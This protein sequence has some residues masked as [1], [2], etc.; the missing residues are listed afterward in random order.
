MDKEKICTKCGRSSKKVKFE[1][2]R[3]VCAECRQKQ[4]LDRV[5]ALREVHYN[6]LENH[7]C[8]HCGEKNPLVLQLH[9]KGGNKLLGISEMIN[10]G[11]SWKNIKKEIDKCEV[12]CANCHSIITVV[13]AD[14]TKL[15]RFFEYVPHS[16]IELAL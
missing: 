7:S 16:L 9:H 14:S 4:K 10:N 5:Y 11:Y 12:L 8:I 3:R 2:H 6:Y 1:K 15:Q 13:E